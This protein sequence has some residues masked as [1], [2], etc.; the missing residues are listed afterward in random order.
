MGCFTSFARTSV[1]LVAL[2]LLVLQAS[3]EEVKAR[4]G[5][6][7]AQCSN[8]VDVGDEW[9]CCSDCSAPQ[10]TDADAQ[11]GYCQM[12]ASL[13]SQLKPREVFRWNTGEWTPCSRHCGEGVRKRRVKCLR[14]VEHVL[15]L[16]A[17][18][19]DSE[20]LAATMVLLFF[21]SFTF[22][23]QFNYLSMT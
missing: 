20:C 6:D 21:L 5:A 17:V 14:Y 3:G 2:S 18:V 1:A 8:K 22:F 7:C 10:I 16:P 12:D 15:N 13:G 11:V 4:E 19:D 9:L 23:H